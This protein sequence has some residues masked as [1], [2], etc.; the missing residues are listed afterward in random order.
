MQTAKMQD[1]SQV[2]DLRFIFLMMSSVMMWLAENV[3]I[4]STLT[5]LVIGAIYGIYGIVE[6]HN[7]IV[8]AKESHEK[9]MND[10]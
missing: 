2:F 1:W 8:Q 3:D 5:F 6:R 4:V 7:R 9:E 10:G